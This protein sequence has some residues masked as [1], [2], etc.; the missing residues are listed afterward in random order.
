MGWSG[1]IWAWLESDG[2]PD[3]ENR[4][5]AGWFWM[6]LGGDGWGDL[7]GMDGSDRR[8]AGLV[9]GVGFGWFG[10]EAKIGLEQC[11]PERSGYCSD[12][13]PVHCSTENPLTYYS[14]PLIGT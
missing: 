1:L 14:F 3:R 9:F 7:D 6:E 11:V 10:R 12:I 5:W 4:I 8:W 2:S 13:V